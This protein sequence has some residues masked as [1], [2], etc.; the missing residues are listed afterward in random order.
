MF[1]F[2]MSFLGLTI[3]AFLFYLMVKE[4]SLIT[5]NNNI[6]VGKEGVKKSKK[7]SLNE[8]L[9]VILFIMLILILVVSTIAD[10]SKIN[11][12]NASS[13]SV[14]INNG[15]ASSVEEK[16][17]L[18]KATKEELMFLGGIGEVKANKIIEYREDHPFESV[19]ELLNVIGIQTYDN[20]KGAVTVEN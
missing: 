8:I 17:D 2:S 12:N 16:I 4:R 20:I 5:R 6:I 15:E 13:A 18:N 3:A 11:I 14:V 9:I 10:A 1:E 7:Y 19:S